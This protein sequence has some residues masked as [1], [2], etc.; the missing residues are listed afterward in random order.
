M[1]GRVKTWV[2]VVGGVVVVGILGIVAMAGVGVYLFS[3][4]IDTKTATPASASRDFETIRAQFTGQTPLIELD[5]RGRYLRSNTDRPVPPG[6]TPP[7][8]LNVIAFD[9][10]DNRIV[11]VSIPFWLLRM[12]MKGTTIDFNGSQMDLED[13][14][15][16]VEDLERYG[17]ALIVDHANASGERV[18]VWSQ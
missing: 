9:P 16:T 6:A 14:K 15:L 5:E 12:K 8:A 17:A 18:L 7:N 4:H 11:R 10:D 13:L 2:W 1:A 3:Q